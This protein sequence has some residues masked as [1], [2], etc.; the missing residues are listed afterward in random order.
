MKTFNLRCDLAETKPA[1][2]LYCQD[3]ADILLAVYSSED[4][5]ASAC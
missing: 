3:K 2:N 4:P 1:R 5:N